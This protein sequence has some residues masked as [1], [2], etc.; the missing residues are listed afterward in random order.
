MQ[1]Q[2]KSEQVIFSTKKMNS[3]KKIMTQMLLQSIQKI[4]MMVPF[5]SKTVTTKMAHMTTK[6]HLWKG[7]NSKTIPMKVMMRISKKNLMRK[8]ISDN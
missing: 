7:M 8:P 2:S 6:N 4:V 5:R 1:L 3:K